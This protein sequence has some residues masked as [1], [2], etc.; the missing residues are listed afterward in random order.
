MNEYISNMNMYP[1]GMSTIFTLMALSIQRCCY[2]WCPTTMG[3]Y[4]P[5]YTYLALILV[6]VMT[7]TFAFPPLLGWSEY[8]PEK[9]GTR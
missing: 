3:V 8:V 5:P 6:W 9:S 1:L 2:V 4:G 7:C